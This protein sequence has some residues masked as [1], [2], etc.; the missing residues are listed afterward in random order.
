MKPIFTFITILLISVN[1]LNAQDLIVTTQGDSI[2]CKITSVTA[3]RIR[4]LVVH[5]D[6]L[7]KVKI[8]AS[9][10]KS[11]EKD[12]YTRLAARGIQTQ[13][14]KSKLSRITV[15]PYGGLSYLI[16]RVSPEVPAAFKQ[17]IKELKSGYHF[18][19]DAT[20]FISER[21]GVGLKYANFG[22]S[23]EA[24]VSG[25]D[26]SGT[27]QTGIMRDDITI[28]YIAP[29]LAS[30]T[31]FRNQTTILNTGFSLGYLSYENNA[32]LIDQFK[33]TGSTVG[34]GFSFGLENKLSKNLGLE[35]GLGMI[36][37]SLSQFEKTTGNSKQTITL[38]KEKRENISRIDV[39]V[40]L[41]WHF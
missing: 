15:S 27:T 18:G 11:S 5:N 36:A 10:V 2:R 13:N 34:V 7:R 26:P 28:Q 32:T 38:E 20:V 16:A 33:L 14:P 17:Y 6:E 40:G 19:A 3:E 4:C 1:A 23:N 30:R 9:Q 8:P 41:K 35:F 37:G 24:F 25:T 21:T 22:T 31:V 39:S 29:V 12:Y